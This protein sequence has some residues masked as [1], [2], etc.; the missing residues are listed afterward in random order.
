VERRG[1]VRYL[2][3]PEYFRTNMT[4]LYLDDT[5]TASELLTRIPAGRSGTATDIGA[6]VKFLLGSQASFLSGATIP[7]AGASNT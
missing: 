5:Q 2:L 7:V 6:T 3:V 1:L 4:A